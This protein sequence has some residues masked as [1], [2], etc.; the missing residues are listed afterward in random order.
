MC[1]FEIPTLCFVFI[2]PLLLLLSVLIYF[3]VNALLIGLQDSHG[4]YETALFLGDVHERINGSF[5]QILI[6]LSFAFCL[7]DFV[8]A[9]KC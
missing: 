5:P 7:A 9:S 6:G 2:L 8:T 4:Q 3:Y 1:N